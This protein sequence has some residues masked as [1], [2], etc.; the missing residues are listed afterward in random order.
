MGKRAKNPVPDKQATCHVENKALRFA[1]MTNAGAT[2]AS[3]SDDV[4]GTMTTFD[5]QFDP[6][7]WQQLELLA[8]LT[9][10]EQMRASVMPTSLPQRCYAARCDGAFPIFRWQS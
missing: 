6:I 3:M 5:L 2:F 9:P 8:K 4:E 7:D 10:G 1:Q